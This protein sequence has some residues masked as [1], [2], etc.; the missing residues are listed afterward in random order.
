MGPARPV[1]QQAASQSN[2]P[3]CSGLQPN[4][5]HLPSFLLFPNPSERAFFLRPPLTQGTSSATWSCG[6]SS[7]MTVCSPRS[8]T[9]STPSSSKH[10]SRI[11]TS[12]KHIS[13]IFTIPQEARTRKRL[14][15]RRNGRKSFGSW[16]TSAVILPLLPLTYRGQRYVGGDFFTLPGHDSKDYSFREWRVMPPAQRKSECVPG[17]AIAPRFAILSHLS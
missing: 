2:P 7:G 16:P 5:P 12:S 8:S 6:A 9:T 1:G 15:L 10:I 14:K 3:L 17:F 4:Q 11:F 13:R